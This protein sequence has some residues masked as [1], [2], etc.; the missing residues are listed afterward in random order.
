MPV[1]NKRATGA[2]L[3]RQNR[4]FALLGCADGIQAHYLNRDD[5]LT[6]NV[7]AK[8]GHSGYVHVDQPT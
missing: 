4:A 5:V 3:E 7:V 2:G 6:L 1:P 8:L